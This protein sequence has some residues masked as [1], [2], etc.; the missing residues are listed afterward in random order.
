M[1]DF[2]KFFPSKWLRAANVTEPVNVTISET[3]EERFEDDS[4]ADIRPWVDFD[5]LEKPLVLNKTNFKAIEEI[6]G[7]EN[8]NEWAGNVVNLYVVKVS[9]KK[10]V[11][12]AIRV[13]PRQGEVKKSKVEK[14][15]EQGAG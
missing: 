15:F 1:S 5:E 6:T 10:D 13:R 9:Y 14:A 4:E 2:D 8:M 3:G 11:F 12:D 7:S